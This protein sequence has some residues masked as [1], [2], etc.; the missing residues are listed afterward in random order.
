MINRESLT[1][2]RNPALLCSFGKESMLLLESAREV[3][4]D[5]TVLWF[6]DRLSKFAESMIKEND[7]CVYSYAPADRYLVPNGDGY[8]LID[9][10]SFGKTFVPTVSDLVESEK[11]E[12][13]QLS[14]V[15][16]PLF[17]YQ[18]DL[19]LWGARSADTHPLIGSLPTGRF[20]LGNT[21]ME[22]PLW[23]WSTDE[24][25]DALAERRIPFEADTNRIEVC[26]GCLKQIKRT[27][28]KKSLKAFEQRFGFRGGH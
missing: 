23:N 2:A 11:C 10:Y 1:K 5:I 26:S 9:E 12:I 28:G 19:T 14:T 3:R 7:L 15:R 27:V 21:V 8:S 17:N 6:G 20:R 16:T 22:A 24:V 13:E 18:F 4:P 25:Y